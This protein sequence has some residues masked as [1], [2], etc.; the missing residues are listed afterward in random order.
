MSVFEILNL[1]SQWEELARNLNTDID[2]SIS[3]LKTFVEH[4]YKSNRF[5]EGWA[6]AMEIAETIIKECAK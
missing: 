4:S 2:S 5:K 1:R 6:E 3:G